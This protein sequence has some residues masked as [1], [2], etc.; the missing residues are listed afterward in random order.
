MIR[1]DFLQFITNNSNAKEPV[2]RGR[3]NEKVRNSS[4]EDIFSR[5]RE[6]SNQIP[7]DKNDNF[8]P[9]HEK[10]QIATTKE[11]VDK[12]NSIKKQYHQKN[13]DASNNEKEF[14]KKIEE[15]NLNPEENDYD[16]SDTVNKKDK[17]DILFNYLAS[18][19][20]KTENSNEELLPN[21][22]ISEDVENQATDLT[23]TG[24]TTNTDIE[25]F[26]DFVLKAQESVIRN[27]YNEMNI[28][29]RQNL[30]EQLK[31]ITEALM[32]GIEAKDNE[33]VEPD[34]IILKRL[35]DNKFIAMDQRDIK[36]K[37]IDDKSN[38]S[39]NK[40]SFKED[41][42]L[43]EKENIDKIIGNENVFIFE[44]ELD[45]EKTSDFKLQNNFT[46]YN[47][48]NQSNIE[49]KFETTFES[50][51][52]REKPVAIDKESIFDQIVE[53]VKIDI[54]K[55]DEIRIKLKPD[56]LGEISLKISTE[57]GVVTAKAYVENL[58]IKQL[59]ESN[60]DNLR[61]NFKELGLNFEALDVS[62]GK[63]SSFEKNNSHTWKQERRK[64]GKE[65]MLEGISAMSTYL[66]GMDTI[67]DG[68]YTSN[69]NI[70]ITV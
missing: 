35:A 52:A 54:D 17:T 8:K 55:T 14:S 51:V 34:N 6:T 16:N 7:S 39:L 47:D 27:E 63:D 45:T 37:Q 25:Q 18:L 41:V 70:D 61:E 2:E 5:K 57:K 64:K 12:E 49:K 58:N 43:E 42:E 59:I 22:L 30:D 24:L 65:P 40:T 60:V 4:F 20:T 13:K 19:L 44:E 15:S 11:V 46:H 28:D 66:E 21:D 9:R 31:Q 3:K 48:S 38:N 69:G 1:T 10:K 23:L 36:E 56:F 32:Q 26:L 29:F 33:D 68:L 67:V 50:M 62:V 53:K